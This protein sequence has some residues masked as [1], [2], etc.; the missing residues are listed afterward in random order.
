MAAPMRSVKGGHLLSGSINIG[1]V[2]PYHLI[3]RPMRLNVPLGE[4]VICP[5]G[6]R[7][8]I[9]NLKKLKMRR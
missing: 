3:L 4:Q 1:R 7:F 6:D 8:Q 9:W 2:W 5:K